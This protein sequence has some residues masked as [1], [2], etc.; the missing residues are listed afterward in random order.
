[1]HIGT[2]K[3]RFPI[4]VRCA[5]FVCCIHS[6]LCAVRAIS[7]EI[8]RFGKPSFYT[9][10]RRQVVWVDRRL[11]TICPR[12]LAPGAPVFCGQASFIS[13]SGCGATIVPFRSHSLPYNAQ[14]SPGE[15]DGRPR[16]RYEC[17]ISTQSRGLRGTG[18]RGGRPY[19]PN[20]FGAV[21]PVFGKYANSGPQDH[22]RCQ[23]LGTAP[24]PGGGV[25]TTHLLGFNVT[26]KP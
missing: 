7:S 21:I 26:P 8:R 23:I 24:P 20:M 16:S 10:T 22:N 6:V 13:D 11:A 5:R 2:F 1:M 18:F 17:R 3:P 15:T 12:V 4:L 9:T 14:Y 25:P 19:T